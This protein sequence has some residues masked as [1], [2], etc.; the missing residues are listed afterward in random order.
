MRLQKQNKLEEELRKLQQEHSKT[1]RE[2]T[3]IKIKEVKRELDELNTQE[4]QKK[5]LFTRQKYYEGGE[6]SLKLLAFKLRKQ[7]S[8]RT[9]Y[10]IRNTNTNGVETGL[11]NIRKCFKNFYQT[12]YS[13]P[14]LNNDHQIDIF[15]SHLTL[16]TVTSEQNKKLISEI[17]EEELRAVIGKLKG[18][19]SPGMDGFTSEW[20]KEIQDQLIPTLLRAFNC[21]LKEKIIPP[22]WRDAII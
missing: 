17:T 6:K 3:N 14:K 12:L 22:S 15:L 20:Y 8:D 4:I 18:G 21:V 1:L 16:P 10:K 7:Q 19:K 2:V 5:L 11:G 9:I 13:Q